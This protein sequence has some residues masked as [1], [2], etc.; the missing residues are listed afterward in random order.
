[1]VVEICKDLRYFALVIAVIYAGFA[2]AFAVLIPGAKR[3]LCM[4]CTQRGRGV[5]CAFCNVGL[6]NC[7]TS[8]SPWPAPPSPLA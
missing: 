4:F 6:L 8:D 5:C 2:I 7:Q 1:M 3:M